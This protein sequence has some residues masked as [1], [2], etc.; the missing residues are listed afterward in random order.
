MKYKLNC[1]ISF[2]L[3]F[4]LPDAQHHA[5]TAMFAQRRVLAVLLFGVLAPGSSL[6]I[7]RRVNSKLGR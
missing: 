4:V 1:S 3:E 7:N 2:C 6:S 5:C